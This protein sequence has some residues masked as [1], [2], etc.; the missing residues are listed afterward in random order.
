VIETEYEY[1]VVGSGAGGGTVAARLAE[2]G[3]KVVLLEAGGDP[4]EARAG[5][6]A[7][8]GADRLPAEYDVPGFTR[9]RPRTQP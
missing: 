1:I 7:Q 9:L 8:P 2:A 4:R 6:V 5:N 3:C